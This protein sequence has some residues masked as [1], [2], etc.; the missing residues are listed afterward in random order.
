M[1]DDLNEDDLG[2]GMW[3]T[4]LITLMD[5]GKPILKVDKP[6]PGLGSWTIYKE[7]AS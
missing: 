3:E 5:M 1:R 6:F 4:V 2:A 7:K